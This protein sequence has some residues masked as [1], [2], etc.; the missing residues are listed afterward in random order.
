VRDLRH[1]A[2][3]VALVTLISTASEIR[4]EPE[5]HSQP[6]RL[7][8]ALNAH[9]IGV[10]D[11]RAYVLS[12]GPLTMR[13]S[14]KIRFMLGD[15]VIA[16]GYVE[17]VYDRELVVAAVVSG[18]LTGVSPER[19]SMVLERLALPSVPK[20]RVGVPSS[21]RSSFLFRCDSLSVH[22][23][24]SSTYYSLEQVSQR[25]FLQ[26]RKPDMALGY[27]DTLFIRL[28]DESTDEE[29]ALE[30]GDLDVAVFW[31][32][33][34]SEEI[35]R[36]PRWQFVQAGLPIHLMAMDVQTHDSTIAR[37]MPLFADLAT[38]DRDLFRGDLGLEARQDS[39][40]ASGTVRYEVDPDCPGRP[41]I[42]RNLNRSKKPHRSSI[43]LF[44]A[45]GESGSLVG[46]V[47]DYLTSPRFAAPIRQR[48]VRLK[49]AEFPIDAFGWGP[50]TEADAMRD[51]SGVTEICRV[52]LIAVSAVDTDHLSLERLRD[53]LDGMLQYHISRRR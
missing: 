40:G 5:P 37:S 53:E 23:Y 28:F 26:V 41:I 17:H 21:A 7:L 33:E 44:I 49:R 51:S 11:E 13:F 25:T 46:N 32:G 16:V 42:E 34:M 50:T 43:R 15:S 10:R 4:S 19:L 24:V 22:T 2:I 8:A 30:R 31:P 9:L 20:V 27:P 18:S 47:A 14:D 48:G 36:Q 29:I 12:T 1:T 45:E 52:N 3:A 39:S 38:L 35:R 6:P